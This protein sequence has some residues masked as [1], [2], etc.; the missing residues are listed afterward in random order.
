MAT[1][2]GE[3]YLRTQLDSILLQTIPFEELVIVDDASTDSTWGIISEYAEK[4]DRIKPFRNERNMGVTKNFERALAYCTGDYIALSDQDD[5]WFP[6]HLEI[7]AEEI[8]N[9]YLIAGDAEIA[10]S[11]GVPQ[12]VKLS[13]YENCDRIPDDNLKKAYAI[14]F[15]KNSWYGSLMMIKKELLEKALPIPEINNLHDVWISTLA[16]FSGG[17]MKRIDKIIMYYRRH[18]NTVTGNIY[19]D[20]RIKNMLRRL[21]AYRML[22]HRPLLTAAIRSRLATNLT[23]KQIRVLDRAD[24]YYQRRKTLSGRIRNLFFDIMHFKS[25][26]S[27]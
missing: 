11:N 25:I 1:Y 10:N 8:G 3:K 19:R 17:G 12:G 7:L 18:E 15:N 20:P 27:C 23:K 16:C 9:N 24:R 6:D 22:A 4:D 13:Y 14:L 2:N 21:K 5:I 26:Y